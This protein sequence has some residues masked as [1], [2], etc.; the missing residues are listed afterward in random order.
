MQ[1]IIDLIEAGKLT[2]EYEKAFIRS[3]RTLMSVNKDTLHQ[4]YNEIFDRLKLF[5]DMYFEAFAKVDELFDTND[6]DGELT[7]FLTTPDAPVPLNLVVVTYAEDRLM[8][9]EQE[10]DR[11]RQE[12]EAAVKERR[13][14]EKPYLWTETELSDAGRMLQFY[15]DVVAMLKAEMD[16]QEAKSC[17]ND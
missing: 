11:V 4:Q 7:T 17:E 1:K 13:N 3:A 14:N 12:Y 8:H 16:K 6:K 10:R 5:E 15:D 9:F 2:D